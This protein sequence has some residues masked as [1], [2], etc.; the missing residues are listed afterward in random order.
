MQPVEAELETLGDP[1][2]RHGRSSAFRAFRKRP[3][4]SAPPRL[5]SG[6]GRDGGCRPFFVSTAERFPHLFGR[7]ED[8]SGGEPFERG[9]E[10]DGRVFL[11]RDGDDGAA[12]GG[13][14]RGPKVGGQFAAPFDVIVGDRPGFRGA[15]ARR[16]R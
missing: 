10:L 8:L 6:G 2:L 9:E 7:V 5:G 15:P 3:P 1:A 16:S 12:R 13:E 14:H 4:G 11:L